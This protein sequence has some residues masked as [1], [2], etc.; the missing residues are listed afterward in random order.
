MEEELKE[1]FKK[2]FI[3][4][5]DIPDFIIKLIKKTIQL[6]LDNKKMEDENINLECNINDLKKQIRNLSLRFFMFTNIN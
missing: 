6:K 1:Y 3:E 2:N 4:Y 5:N